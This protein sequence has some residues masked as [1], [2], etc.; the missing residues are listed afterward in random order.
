MP[1]IRRCLKLGQEVTE[2]KPGAVKG[3]KGD[4]AIN[5]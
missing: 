4:Y 1:V 5:Q 3:S 2:T